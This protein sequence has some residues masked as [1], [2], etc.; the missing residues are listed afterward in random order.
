MNTKLRVKAFLD[1]CGHSLDEYGSGERGFTREDALRFL[2]VLRES[3]FRPL[4]VDVWRRHGAGLAAEGLDAW[5]PD[6]KE[7]AWTSVAKFLQTT[8]LGEGELFTIQF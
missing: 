4:G 1:T 5:Y 3:G 6:G 2:E 7:E 8:S